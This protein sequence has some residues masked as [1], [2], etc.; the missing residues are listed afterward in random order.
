VLIWEERR[1]GYWKATKSTETY[2]K[3]IGIEVWYGQEGACQNNVHG[4]N[5]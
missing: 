2:F 5:G 1:M 3:N 4:H